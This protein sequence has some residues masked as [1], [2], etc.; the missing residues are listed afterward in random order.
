MKILMLVPFLPI[1]QMSGGQTRWFHLIKHLSEKH[2]ITLMSLIKDEEEKEY[3]PQIEK[4]CKKVYVFKRPKSP[5]TFRNLFLTLISFNPLVVIR[6]FSMEE[7]SAIYKELSTNEYDLIHAE[8]F[9]VMPHIPKTKIPIILVEPTIEYSVY[10]HY[11]DNEVN[12]ILKPIYMFDILKLKFWE[13]FYWRRASRLFAVSEDD[14]KVMQKEIPTKDVGVISNGVDLEFFDSKK[15]VKKNPPRILYHGNYK[16]MQNVEAVNL[17]VHEIW[18]KIKKE[19]KDVKLWISGRNVPPEIIA[20]S[21][22]DKDIEISESIKDNRDIYKASTVLVTPIRGPGGTRLKVLEAMASDLPVVS[23]P[24]GVAGLGIIEG[25]H[26]LVSP[27]ME[28]LSEMVIDLLK[29]KDKAERIGKAGREF[30]KINFD[31]SGIV[32]K[33]NKVYDATK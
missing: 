12:P 11:V 3:L 18:P 21:K 19:I 10:K 30:V 13:K 24:V 17:L 25:K 27:N 23:T 6:N 22:L 32:A 26:A 31:W 8:T 28:T 9:Y 15:V 29:N 1:D 4:Y 14:K 2:E 16:W 33:L 7:R 5:W 20:Y